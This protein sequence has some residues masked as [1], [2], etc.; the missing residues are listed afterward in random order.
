M[1]W[2]S[3]HLASVQ[4]AGWNRLFSWHRSERAAVT[5]SSD[6]TC[7][8][9]VCTQRE[10]ASKGSVLHKCKRKKISHQKTSKV[11]WKLAMGHLFEKGCTSPVLLVYTFFF[12]PV[13]V[14]HLQNAW[15]NHLCIFLA[16]NLYVHNFCVC[17]CFKVYAVAH[18]HHAHSDCFREPFSSLQSVYSFIVSGMNSQSLICIT[19]WIRGWIFCVFCPLPDV[20]M[21]NQ[22]NVDCWWSSGHCQHLWRRRKKKEGPWR[23]SA[24]HLAQNKHPRF[25]KH[26]DPNVPRTKGFLNTHYWS[27]AFYLAFPA[28]NS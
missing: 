2:W 7:L 24:A 4:Q 19:W 16:Y 12:L 8:R 11:P 1:L 20:T 3:H 17:A 9:Q 15:P 26:F 28:C 25:W 10:K 13:G 14:S 21:L 5:C 23:L 18:K 22:P 27:T 6:L